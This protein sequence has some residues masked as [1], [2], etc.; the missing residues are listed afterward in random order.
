MRKKLHRV[1][2]GTADPTLYVTMFRNTIVDTS[3][4]NKWITTECWINLMKAKYNI[5]PILELTSNG[6]NRAI[7]S[8]P[9]FKMANID[10]VS[11]TNGL[12]I[13]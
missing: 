6:L 12:G 9:A 11:S 1:T 10:A 3:Y 2:T 13:F 7:G 8:H 5:D 4:W